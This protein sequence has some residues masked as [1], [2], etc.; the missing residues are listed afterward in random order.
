MMVLSEHCSMY[1]SH[2]YLCMYQML[3]IASVKGTE[4]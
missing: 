1:C 2:G 4:M 3:Q